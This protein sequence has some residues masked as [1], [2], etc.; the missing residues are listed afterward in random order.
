ML[1]SQV[2]DISQADGNAHKIHGRECIIRI[3]GYTSQERTE[4]SL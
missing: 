2:P 4:K 1:H 3:S